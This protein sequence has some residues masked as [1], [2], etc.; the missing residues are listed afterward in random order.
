MS[1]QV[2]KV[3]RGFDEVSSVVTKIGR[4][5]LAT[6]AMGI[7]QGDVYVLLKPHEQWKSGCTK[8]E[9]IDQMSQA[10]SRIPG[11]A[12]NFTATD[13]DAVGRGDLRRK[14]RRRA[15]DFR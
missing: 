7:Y 5:D 12:Y 15:E 4:P 11:V 8:E 14:G 6:E 9:L 13:G 3:I 10:L 2:E 1:T